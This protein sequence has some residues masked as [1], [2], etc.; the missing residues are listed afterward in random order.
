MVPASS[1]ELYNQVLFQTGQLSTGQHTL[2]VTYQGNSETAPLVLNYLVI[3]NAGSTSTSSNG[4]IFTQSTSS[5]PSGS[6][7][8]P[9]TNANNTASTS[10]PPSSYIA[11]GVATGVSGVTSIISSGIPSLNGSSSSSSTSY[12]SSSTSTKPRLGAILGGALGGF[13]LFLL[14][15]IILLF[16]RRPNNQGAHILTD[17]SP[18]HTPR[19]V[20]NSR[21]VSPFRATP[22][23]NH[24]LDDQSF[25]TRSFTSKFSQG[26]R[27]TDDLITS[28]IMRSTSPTDAPSPVSQSSA[29]AISSSSDVPLAV[30]PA[31]GSGATTKAE[32][33]QRS[34][35]LQG[36]YSR[37]LRYEDSGIRMPPGEENLLE[38]PPSYSPG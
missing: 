4:G 16:K 32:M 13:I 22:T 17:T 30:L 7:A 10:A 35:T 5:S 14:L 9:A 23:T 2:V 19:R 34:A 38:L 25:T 3:Q 24:T 20:T 31:S 18:P 33:V 12:L 27:V 37:V 11:T 28:S 1:T 6:T 36:G 15:I 29:V 26:R 21:M 8:N